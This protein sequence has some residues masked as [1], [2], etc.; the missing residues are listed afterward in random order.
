MTIVVPFDGSD[1]SEAALCR[2]AELD[3]ALG[4]TLL[5]VTVVPMGNVDYAR[6]RDW[7]GPTEPFDA[8][9]IR[10]R[11]E[12][13]V[14]DCSPDAEFRMETVDRFAQSGTIANRLRRIARDENASMVCLGSE[15][16]GRIV[17]AVSSVGSSV[18]SDDAY[19]LFIVRHGIETGNTVGGAR[20]ER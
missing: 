18:A 7:L 10:S 19:D 14:E 8:R 6:E 11:L 9:T 1:L 4:E 15:N 12:G 20:N 5:A 3:E 13:Y 2:A 17:T 16:A